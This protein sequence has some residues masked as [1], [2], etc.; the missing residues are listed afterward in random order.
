M[1]FYAKPFHHSI[2][3]QYVE[4]WHKE[5]IVRPWNAPIGWLDARQHTVTRLPSS[6][7]PLV[8][9]G[10]MRAL[11]THMA[12]C[13]VDTGVSCCNPLVHTPYQQACA[14]CNGQCGLLA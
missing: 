13:A 6:T 8:C 5:G 4:Q 12:S 3:A 11:A 7:T 9:P 2:V 10:G 1:A 14:R